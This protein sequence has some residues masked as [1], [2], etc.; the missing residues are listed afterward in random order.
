VALLRAPAA[1]ASAAFVIGTAAGA[2]ARP[3]TSAPAS[4][5]TYVVT[6]LICVPF[7]LPTLWYRRHRVLWLWMASAAALATMR[8]VFMA[9]FLLPHQ[10]PVEWLLK[11][12]MDLL[13]ASALCVAAAAVKRI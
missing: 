12:G 2:V 10:T 3:F 9:G 4:P 5:V 13:A 1:I 7:L 11:T 6:L 8:A